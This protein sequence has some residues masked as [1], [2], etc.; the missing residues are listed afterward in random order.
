MLFGSILREWNWIGFHECQTHEEEEEEWGRTAFPLVRR[1]PVSRIPT[2]GHYYGLIAA[3]FTV[4]SLLKLRIILVIFPIELNLLHRFILWILHLPVIVVWPFP[5]RGHSRLSS[6]DGVCRG[7]ETLVMFQGWAS[8]HHN[9]AWA[10]GSSFSSFKDFIFDSFIFFSPFLGI[11]CGAGL[12]HDAFACQSTLGSWPEG[13]P[14]SKGR[15]SVHFSAFSMCVWWGRLAGLGWTEGTWV[16]EVVVVALTQSL[17]LLHHS[18][19]IERKTQN[20]LRYLSY[21][22][23]SFFLIKMCYGCDKHK[24][25]SAFK[26]WIHTHYCKLHWISCKDLD[27]CSKH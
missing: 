27:T 3:S 19:S 4:L 17:P 22:H 24:C 14:L 8:W 12:F 6:R 21:V 11:T 18:E 1:I 25:V 5:E 15:C 2:G 10:G 13:S 20:V 16:V 23:S 9:V 26:V 7:H